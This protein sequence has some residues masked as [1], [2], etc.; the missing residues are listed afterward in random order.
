MLA[1]HG[2]AEFAARFLRDA[3]LDWAADLLA[4]F[5]ESGTSD[6]SSPQKGELP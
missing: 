6:P 5:P 3:G 2:E 1:G 4:G